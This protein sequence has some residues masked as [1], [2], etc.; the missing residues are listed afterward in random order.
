MTLK[1]IFRYP[2]GKRRV[3]PIIN[4]RF[5]KIDVRID[6]FTGSS[7]W[8]LASE[9]AKYEVVNDADGYVVNYL[10]AIREAPDEVAR[11]LDFPAAELEIMATGIF[12]KHHLSELAAR[13]GADPD[14]YD[15]KTAARWAYLMA[16]KI[17][18]AA[19]EPGAWGVK[20]GK[21]TFG[22]KDGIK[23]YGTNFPGSFLA[24][25]VKEGKVSEYLNALAAR[26]KN[27][28]ILWN[29]F[30]TILNSSVTNPRNGIIGI[31][32]D[33]P[34]TP[35]KTRV[36][37]TIESADIWDRAARWAVANGKKQH[38]RIAVCGYFTEEADAMFPQ[39]WERYRWKQTGRLPQQRREC[40]WF[41]PLCE[42]EG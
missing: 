21:L 38:L 24:R 6:A 22:I 28:T 33:P 5:G 35:M 16:H 27:V 26:L 17:T 19:P 37:Y 40:I 25:L 7:A 8:I 29:D 4:Q 31:L 10:R 30:E 23:R 9:P 1:Q 11:Y 2:G 41:S 42:K 13:L 20:D 3:V 34:Y 15:A 36:V 12:Q 18:L 14:Y 39:T 32:L